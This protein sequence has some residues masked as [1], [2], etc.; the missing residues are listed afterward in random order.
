MKD[1]AKKTIVQ[2]K[3][4]NWYPSQTIAEPLGSKHFKKM[5]SGTPNS[6][7]KGRVAKR[8]GGGSKGK[9][10]FSMIC[11]ITREVLK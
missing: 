7:S 6:R 3:G 2:E 8:R 10:V 5:P 9:K 1:T 11:S 4:K